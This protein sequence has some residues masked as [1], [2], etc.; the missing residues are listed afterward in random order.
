[1]QKIKIFIFLICLLTTLSSNAQSMRIY[2]VSSGLS[3]NSI[4][5][6]T[7]DDR[8][9]I[10]FA[11]TDGLNVFNGNE[12]KSFGCSYMPTGKD[13]I[14]TLN[15]MTL[16]LHKDR[17]KIWVGTQTS[18]IYLF[19]P[20]DESFSKIT[21]NSY[22]KNLPDPNLCYTLANDKDGKLWIGTDHGIYIYDE[23]NKSFEWLSTLNSNLASN[24]VHKIFCDS[25]GVIWVGSTKGL[26]KY[27]PATRRF[28]STK[29]TKNT[30][31]NGNQIHITSITEGA[32][33]NLWIG[34]WNKGLALLD[35]GSNT[36]TAIRPGGDNEYASRMR[37]RS[38]LPENGEVLWIC[39][40]YGLF[41]YNVITNNLSLIVLSPDHP[42][43]NIYSILKDKEG[44]IWIGTL[45]QGVYYLSHRAR[46]IECYTPLYEG[47]HLKGS[48]I[49]SFHEDSNGLIYVA[50]ENGGLSLFDPN[51]KKF[52][53]T[54]I[55]ISAN[56][57][58]A[59]CIDENELYIGTYSQG[60]KIADLATGRVQNLSKRHYPDL[61]SNNIFSL[62][63][64]DKGEIYIGTDLGCCIYNKSDRSLKVISELRG[65][66]IYNIKKDRFGNLWFATFYN[67]IFRYN[68]KTET[69]THYVHNENEPSSL[70][71]NKTVNLYIDDSDTLWICTEGG[72]ICRYDY[73]QDCFHRL[74]MKHE[75]KDV[76]LS[77]VSNILT[78]ADGKLWI[79]SNNGLWICD[80]SGETIKHLTHE[81]GLQS[82]Q[83]CIGSSL[84]SSSGK[85]YF[86]GVNGFNAINPENIK[87]SKIRPNVTARISFN[88]KAGNN[89][90]SSIVLHSEEITLPRNVS[91]FSI[92]FE[93]LSYSAPEKNEFAYSID[94]N[95]DWT[96]TYE[97]SVTFLNF[98]YGEHTIKVKA[99]NGD[100]LWS[101]NEACLT[102][103]N[104]TP[105]LKSTVAKVTYILLILCIIFLVVI[106][107]EKRHSEKSQIKV[108]EI[109]AVQEQETYKAKIDFFTHVAHEIKT[110]VTLIKAPLEVILKKRQTE[111]NRHDL[112]IMAKNTDRL[113]DLVNQ[114]LDFKKINSDGHHIKVEPCDPK[115]LIKNVTG[116]FDGKALGG[117]DI[118]TNLTEQE[119]RCMIDPEAY[120]KIISNLM[121][122]AVKHA[123]SSICVDL[124]L[125]TDK[126]DNTLHM[127]VSDDGCGIPE[128]EKKKIFD[129][130]YQI[131]TSENPR[132]S[133]VGLGLSLVKLLVQKHNGSVYVDE[134]VSEGCRI[135]VDIPYII[136]AE[137]AEKSD[138]AKDSLYV[139]PAAQ[140]VHL[141]ANILIAEDTSDML[142][143]IS[144]VFKDKHLVYKASNGKEALEILYRHEIDI[145]ISDISMPI[146]N[147][148]ELLQEIRRNDMFCHIPVIMLTVENTLES[149]IKGLEYGADA[150]IEK[151]FSTTHLS[152]TVENL[153]S[154]REVL[155]KRYTGN[156]LK[157]DNETIKSSR[158]KNW[159]EHLTELINANIQEP[160]I[161]IESLA[162]ELNM[163]RSSFQRKLKGL[164]GLSPVEFIRLI[165]LKK[166]A[167]LLSRGKY[168]VSE[169]AYMVGFN[170]PSYFTSLFKKQ[171][172]VLPKDFKE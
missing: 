15:I 111:D 26:Q 172:G 69:W 6:I 93:C 100:G 146:M 35:R 60:L 51:T 10:W 124:E 123:K 56:N 34:T 62:Y 71:H 57:L 109:K 68:E 154:R 11:T 104:L 131:N 101:E 28:T 94:G 129:S 126:D 122:N 133:G 54:G 116:R 40:D 41:K 49:S 59:L 66:F 153:I 74:N 12:F 137:G 72:G 80:K 9:Y 110:P 157:Q 147:G 138:S 5:E 75:E 99:R 27:N 29:I 158:D 155:Q 53:P 32:S 125:R 163:S 112:E 14:N 156:P 2:D 58:H 152:A 21:I 169:V 128:S 8:G 114:L 82:N 90:R 145:I 121:T 86:G 160:E 118:S 119:L 4:K 13:G 165:R 96:H 36:L 48:A 73:S 20:D 127:A 55:N 161:S 97:P 171:F 85:L 88:D 130:F 47:D 3:S 16:L 170:K 159:F 38:I 76:T 149:K 144:S 87:D 46:Q 45:F 44:G 142:D 7:Q 92:D 151:P 132:I 136:P 167:E 107:I 67:G 139:S 77:M 70:T 140:H 168:R 63:R 79:S 81:D 95:P 25:N 135:C 37:I 22:N 30:F 148:F 134:S 23:Q 43:D 78:D 141:G 91:S 166:A 162:S 103:N 106:T 89:I 52:I 115:E 150:Y 50:S 117:I 83:Y 120:T 24:A 102:I 64:K 42:N 31:Q 17:R 84:R 39:S 113:L 164:T 105:I 143:F 1:M 61:I 18:S 19:N 33:G 65:E 108:N 98:P